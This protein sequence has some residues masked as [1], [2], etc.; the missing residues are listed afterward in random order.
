M[1]AEETLSQFKKMM[2]PARSWL[3]VVRSDIV[4][5]V[6]RYNEIDYSHEPSLANAQEAEINKPSFYEPRRRSARLPLDRI[7]GDSSS[8][9]WPT[10]T[11]QSVLTLLG[12][13]ALMDICSKGACHMDAERSWLNVLL[14]EGLLVRRKPA[15]QWYMSLGTLGHVALGWPVVSSTVGAH[16]FVHLS[17][18]AADQDL[19]FFLLIWLGTSTIGRHKPYSGLAHGV[20][21]LIWGPSPRPNSFI[22]SVVSELVNRLL[23]CGLLL[24]RRFGHCLEH[25]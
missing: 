18:N 22:M 21:S 5:G 9:Q 14:H 2:V 6:H 8:T 11:P 12:D 17:S 15:G 13:M 16:K 3:H 24:V 1:R 10:F 25:S 23:F 7:V 4:S 20:C 19:Q